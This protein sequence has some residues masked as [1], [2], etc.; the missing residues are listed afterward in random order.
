MFHEAVKSS[1]R[2]IHHFKEIIIYEAYIVPWAARRSNQ[3]ILRKSVLNIHWKDWCWSWS[4]NTLATW[5]KEL[6]HWKRP[7]CWESLKAEGEG[8]DRGWDGWMVSPTWRTWVWANSGRWWRTGKSGVLQS[9]G[10]QRVRHDCGTEQ[11]QLKIPYV[12]M[13]IDDQRSR[14]QQLRPSTAKWINI[15]FKCL[16]SIFHIADTAGG[17]SHIILF[18]LKQPP[19]RFSL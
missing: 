17:L 5:C 9:M 6:T 15:F 18:A 12:T 7:W 8:G 4:S 16:R 14:V 1:S 19:R 10:S 11:Q 2:S 3:S 13:K